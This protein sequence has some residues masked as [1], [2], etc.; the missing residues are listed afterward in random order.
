MQATENVDQILAETFRG[1]QR[2]MQRPLLSFRAEAVR[3]SEQCVSPE[4]IMGNEPF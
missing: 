3:G 4:G 2:V 1:K